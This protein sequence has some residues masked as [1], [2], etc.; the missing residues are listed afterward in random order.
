GVPAVAIATHEF[1]TAARAQSAA[2]NRPDYELV[3][4]DHPIQD[5]TRAEIESR[6]D[7]VIDEIV[8]RLT[9]SGL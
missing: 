7:R 6:A 4:V 3:Y 8:A 5:P 1:A 9:G 2:L